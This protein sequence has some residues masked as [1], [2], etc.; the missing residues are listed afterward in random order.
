MLYFLLCSLSLA[1]TNYDRGIA[2]MTEK[3]Y[4][5]ATDEFNSCL[6]NDPKNAKCHWEIG[7]AYWMLSDWDNVLKHWYIVEK[8]NPSQ[9][10]IEQYILQA[11]DNKNVD[12]LVN[13]SKQ[14]APSTFKSPVPEGTTIRIRAVGDM[15]IGTNFPGG[16]LPP[17]GGA[18]MFKGVSSELNDADLTFGNLEGPICS[19]K[20]A[21]SK[22]K[23]SAPGRCYAFRSPPS[24]VQHYK[25]AGFDLLST[26]NNHAND[27]GQT[28]RME[29]EKLL[30]EANIAHSGRPGDIASVE[31]NG[32]KISMI[33]F[34]T[35]RSGHYLNDH[36]TAKKLVASQAATHDIVIVS[37]HGGA[38]GS[39]ATHVPKG[40]ETFLGE[41][42]GNLRLFARDVIDS[43]ADMV[44]GHGPHVLRG[45]EIYNDRLIAYSLGNFATYGRFNISGNNGLGVIL[46]GTLD[47]EG[48]FVYG[49][50][51]ST[52]Q[53]GRGIPVLD[54]SN[55]ASD[56]IRKLSIED[57]GD[58]A[59]QIA[60]DGSI[61]P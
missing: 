26:A 5:L 38:E 13:Q 14:N 16:Y 20:V 6:N 12:V 52:K 39:K 50:L 45:M 10:G 42:R 54:E 41:N 8:Q 25:N 1:D 47:A 56:V 58:S 33:A 11:Q 51:I 43:G 34:H 18:D 59:I 60:Q 7:W 28:C 55:K 48:K 22:C 19:G 3:K 35:S 29:T 2:L 4:R 49:Q 27:F 21:S 57:F 36:E 37:F 40:K 23:N 61:K 32:L 15:M 9:E 17:S 46:E 31:Q 44:I 30:D 53:V 24:Y